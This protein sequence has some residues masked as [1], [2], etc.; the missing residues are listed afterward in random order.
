[1]KFNRLFEA[2]STTEQKVVKFNFENIAS[3]DDIP[4]RGS[5]IK[6]IA[7]GTTGY[8]VYYLYLVDETQKQSYVLRII[9]QGR[10]C[11]LASFG[12]PKLIW[13]FVGETEAKMPKRDN[14]TIEA[15]TNLFRRN[16]AD[17]NNVINWVNTKIGGTIT[18]KDFGITDKSM[19]TY[20][21]SNTISNTRTTSKPRISSN[22]KVGILKKLIKK[23]ITEQK[24]KK[25]P[26]IEINIVDFYFK[27]EKVLSKFYPNGDVDQLEEDIYRYDLYKADVPGYIQKTEIHKPSG[28]LRSERSTYVDII[29][30]ISKPCKE[31]ESL[32]KYIVNVLKCKPLEITSV[33]T[34]RVAGKRGQIF[35]RYGLRLLAHDAKK[36]KD[37]KTTLQSIKKPNWKATIEFKYKL[38]DG[39]RYNGYGEDRELEWDG[40]EYNYAII[41]FKTPGGKVMNTVRL[42]IY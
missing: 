25:S 18:L 9:K 19:N 37:Y 3:F 14:A 6:L 16:T 8:P 40:Y 41:T 4:Y 13:T 30:Y 42:V 15:F 1:M 7:N 36:C 24:S 33:S 35:E 26:V 28:W 34:E 38:E 31:F 12:N 20:S 27:N 39:D 11:K 22:D 23:E 29:H 17:A 5:I 2:L 32:N 10:K 21:S